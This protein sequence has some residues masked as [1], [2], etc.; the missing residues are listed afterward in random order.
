MYNTL[1]R[2]QFKLQMLKVLAL[3]L[4]A[5]ISNAQTKSPKTLAEKAQITKLHC[6][7]DGSCPSN[8][9][10]VQ[11]LENKQFFNCSGFLVQKNIVATN[12]HCLPIELIKNPQLACAKYLNFI[13]IENNKNKV[14]TCKKILDYSKNTDKN[15][16]PQDYLFFEIK[17]DHL[18][19]FEIEKQPYKNNDTVY[20]YNVKKIDNKLS[21]IK[22]EC[23][24][25]LN[26]NL[27]HTFKH[28]YSSKGLLRSCIVEEGNSGAAITSKNNK[29]L[30]IVSAYNPKLNVFYHSFQM[31]MENY[32]TGSSI[33][34]ANNTIYI[35]ENF[36]CIN[37]K[38]NTSFNAKK[39]A[40][41]NNNILSCHHKD[42]PIVDFDFLKNQ[43]KKYQSDMFGYR[44][45]LERDRI[46]RYPICIKNK[47]KSLFRKLK[48]NKIED[49]YN[50][51]FS[52]YDYLDVYLRTKANSKIYIND[53]YIAE[54]KVSYDKNNDKWYIELEDNTLEN[55]KN[56]TLNDCNY[57]DILK[58]NEI[59]V[60]YGF[61]NWSYEIVNS[62]IQ[63]IS[64][65]EY[66]K[67]FN[68]KN[69]I[70]ET[71]KEK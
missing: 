39:C 60:S 40:I 26:S 69:S 71:L 25:I 30:G 15:A 27:R 46:A 28:E 5:P 62:L 21:L 53:T 4:I 23:Q 63:S 3:I 56:Y 8:I 29:I 9:G 45:V 65:S 38:W 10:L 66:L 22:Q 14:Y 20:Q 6:A 35:F 48:T 19:A 70:C 55:K 41:R 67:N 51:Y 16:D 33:K 52:N 11:S 32:S 49:T 64:I 17:A 59:L 13:N 47:A 58:E 12:A 36:K 18:K 7:I 34:A 68:E 44:F 37:T 61:L 54:H 57:L 2:S 31:S 1:L 43:I 50:L 42:Q 24:I